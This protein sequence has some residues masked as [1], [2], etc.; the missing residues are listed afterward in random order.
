[1]KNKMQRGFFTTGK[2]F[3]EILVVSS[4]KEKKGNPNEGKNPEEFKRILVASL[5]LKKK[6]NLSRQ[7]KIKYK[8]DFSPKAKISRKF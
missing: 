1:M 3:K 4:F 2:N 6:G 7:W 5:N 8:G